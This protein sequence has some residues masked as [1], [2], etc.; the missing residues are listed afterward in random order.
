[1][2]RGKVRFDAHSPKHADWPDNPERALHAIAEENGAEY[3]EGSLVFTA[4]GRIGEALF[5][6]FEPG[7][8]KVTN[9]V[10]LAEQL[11]ALELRVLVDPDR[12]RSRRQEQ[13]AS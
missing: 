10:A 13:S 1:M 8:E 6:T 2:P 7:G 4:N 11:A 12:W 3:I 5:R 9:F